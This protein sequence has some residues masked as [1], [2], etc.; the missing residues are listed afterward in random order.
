MKL[1]EA[2]MIVD[3]RGVTTAGAALAHLD[4][5]LW[6]VRRKSAPLARITARHLTFD[7]GRT[8]GAYVSNGHV[9]HSDSVVQRFEGWARTH[10]G[11]FSLRGA[12]RSAGVSE[13]T[14][15]RRVHRV[16]GRPP[17]AFLHDLRVEDA[18]RQLATTD[19][20]VDEIAER[21]GYARARHESDEAT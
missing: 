13:R 14:L 11:R 15:E 6:F 16:L 2:K 4:L 17:I 3:A 18:R 8:Q 9:A 5:A 7:H 21:V 1:D 12:A 19:R 10:L 20:T